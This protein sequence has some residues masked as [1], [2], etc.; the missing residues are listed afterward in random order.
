[1]RIGLGA[2]RPRVLAVIATTQAEAARGVRHALTANS[3]HPVYV[4]CAEAGS[5]PAD[6]ARYFPNATGASLRRDLR[7]LWPALSIVFWSGKFGFAGL[8]S[9]PFLAPPFRVVIG[10][11][12]GGFFS[13]R[14]LPLAKH[15]ARR[16]RDGVVWVA[17][18]VK[19]EAW[20]LLYR[21]GERLRD[22]L[23]LLVSGGLLV[24]AAVAQLTPPGARYFM[25]RM[26]GGKPEPQVLTPPRDGSCVEVA[27]PVRLWPR[28]ALAR[29]VA[30]S[31]AEFIVL[32]ARGETASAEPLIEMALGTNA[33]AVARQQAFA[34]WRA[35]VATKHPFRRLQPGEASEVFA[36]HGTLIVM[37]R[38]TLAEWGVPRAWTAGTALLLLYWRAAAADYA[39][40]ALGDES[41]VGDEPAMALEDA[42][43]VVRLGMSAALRALAPMEPERRRGNIAFLQPAKFVEQGRPRVLVVSPYLPFPLSHGGAVR[44]YNLCRELAGEVDFHLVCFREANEVV[45]YDELQRIFRSVQVVD[46]DEEP[47]ESELPKQVAGYQSGAMAGLIRRS[48]RGCDLVQ[49]EYTQMALY[50]EFAGPVPAILVEHDIT[51]TLYRQLADAAPD[52]A[53]AKEQY[54]LWL[55]FE[56]NALRK[57]DAVW[58]MSEADY[59]LADA[60][61]ARKIRLVPNGVDLQRYQPEPRGP[62]TQTIL[63]VG[64]F[65]HLPNLLAFEALRGRIMP[66]VWKVFPDAKLHAIAGPRHKRAATLAK[67]RGVLTPDSRVRIEGF[68][69]DVRPAYRDCTVVAVPVPVSAG[70]NIKVVEAMAAGRAVVSNAVGCQGLGLADGEDLLVREIGP[71]F[72]QGITALLSD[73]D[74]CERIALHGRRTVE[75]RF[76]WDRIAREGLACYRELTGHRSQSI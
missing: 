26:S 68:V 16:L 13:P 45:R 31:Q 35:R 50:R 48:A 53:G 5:G 63:F 14:P 49:F 44:I 41:R 17:R 29:A 51:W 61:G 76:G 7:G 11:E 2:G 18:R 75:R 6:A 9:A 65:R 66:E 12:A 73:R 39:S 69:E 32:R 20:S 70:T 34:G 33:F 8:K 3:P 10:N 47:V 27:M 21:V 71:E 74:L 37:R 54:D 60:A 40:Y 42:E 64:S 57:A 4:W 38:S 56:T 23:M 55:R 1:M 36:P 58:T 59:L 28:K 25:S 15:F 19:D 22:V 24:L 46:I 62:Q 67:K 30:A 72:A 52:D 43:F